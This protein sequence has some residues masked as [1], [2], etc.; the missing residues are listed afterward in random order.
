MFE[1]ILS[2]FGYEKRSLPVNYDPRYS[3]DVWGRAVSPGGFVSGASV[4]S[5]SSVALRAIDLK[6]TLLGSVPL[7][8]FHRLSEGGR[9]R[10][11]N[12]PLARVLER[13]NAYMTRFEFIELLSRSLDLTGN[14]F[15]RVEHA[16]TG[17]IVALHPIASHRVQVE[18]TARGTIRY[19]VSATNDEP[20]RVLLDGEML[21][22]K[23]P[24]ADGLIGQT[25]IQMARGVL[26]LGQDL[27]GAAVDATNRKQAGFIIQPGE[28]NARQKRQKSESIEELARGLSRYTP[29]A[30][31]PGVKFHSVSFS[32]ADA[33]LLESRKL[34]N[35]DTAR[36]F[37]VPPQAV[38]ILGTTSYGSQQQAQQDLVTN[39]LNPLAARVEAALEKCLLSDEAR[40]TVFVEFELDGLLRADPAERWRTYEVGR[41][42]GALSPNEIRAFEN[43]APYVGGES[44][45]PPA[46]SAPAQSE[47]P[48]ASTN[49]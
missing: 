44:F 17:E 21:H 3:P 8:V 47:P 49:P 20:A 12:I 24:S 28:T 29:V 19:R 36:A 1:R 30:L 26:A 4:L 33:E 2:A 16:A 18:R 40:R 43:L 34:S 7:K 22:V 48:I 31:D 38:G 32:A 15:A 27:H 42:I 35:E 41:R 5:N 13:P 10:A 25:P 39:T 46:K 11:I 23:N 6:A 9:Q 14:F 37:G 45:D